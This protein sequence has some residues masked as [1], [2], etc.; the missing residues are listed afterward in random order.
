MPSFPD[1]YLNELVSFTC[2]ADGFQQLGYLYLQFVDV[3]NNTYQTGCHKIVDG[4]WK[5]ESFPVD[6]MGRIE[7]PFLVKQDCMAAAK[8]SIFQFAIKFRVSQTTMAGKL[9]CRAFDSELG[10]FASSRVDIQQVKGL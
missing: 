3:H 2:T 4:T 8:S 9:H 1:V 5:S 7:P 10:V 6:V